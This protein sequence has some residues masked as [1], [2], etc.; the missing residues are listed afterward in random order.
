[1][2]EIGDIESRFF[3]MVVD[4]NKRGEV[5]R[6]FTLWTLFSP[7]LLQAAAENSLWR[8]TYGHLPTD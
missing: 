1:M 2:R 6:A 8:W 7:S 4:V 5:D 3:L